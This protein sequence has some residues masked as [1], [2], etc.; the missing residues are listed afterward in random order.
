MQQTGRASNGVIKAASAEEP[1]LRHDDAYLRIRR[2]IISCQLSPGQR[3]TEAELM[4]RYEIGKATCRNALLRLLQDGF[5]VSQPRRGYFVKPISVKD[6]D[7]VF[8]LRLELEPMAARLAVGRVDLDQLV[9]WEKACREDCVEM[10][11]ADQIKVFLDANKEFHMTIAA[12]S[13]NRRLHSF[14]RSL[15]DEMSRLAAL[16]FG[17][18]GLKPGI[19]SDHE[20]M[21]DAFRNG[22]GE[23]AAR[24]ARRHVDAFRGMTMDKILVALRDV[25]AEL[26]IT[27]Q[28]RT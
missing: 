7:E 2:D 24:I 14:M 15:L 21:L 16:G 6:V 28:G 20:S 23:E 27:R 11:I 5:V 19:K 10:D 22:D 12:A 13:D 1:R 8:D 3:F 25:S 18:G 9:R 17:F 26:P 4:D